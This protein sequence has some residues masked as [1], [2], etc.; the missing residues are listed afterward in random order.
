MLKNMQYI[1][2][3]YERKSFSKAAEALYISQPALS[4]IVKKAE[5]EIG[6][7]IFD[8]STNPIGLTQAGEYYIRSIEKLMEMEREMKEHL[9][10]M[11]EASKGRLTIGAS[12]FFC[13]HVLPAYIQEFKIQYPGCQVTTLEANTD[14]LIQCLRSG[15]IDLNLDV[16]TL[17]PSVF[18]SEIWSREHI[19]LAVPSGFRINASLRKYRLSRRQA[20]DQ[21]VFDK[22]YPAVKLGLFREEPFLFLKKGNDLYRRGMKM[23]KQ[24]GF[25][26]KIAMYLDQMLTSYYIARDSLGVCFLRAGLPSYMDENDRLCFYKIDDPLSSRDIYLYYKKAAPLS[27]AAKKFMNFLGTRDDSLE[28]KTPRKTARPALS[29]YSGCE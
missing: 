17:D 24:A 21:T 20:A 9:N 6:L 4:T 13:A 2:A 11:A 8:R 12:A 10:G 16:D 29:G 26:P 22:E 5:A 3:V 23:C 19:I 25:T 15:A 7:A 18:S 14:D 1:Y 27:E 28:Q